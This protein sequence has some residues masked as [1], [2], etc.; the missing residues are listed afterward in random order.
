MNKGF[1][2]IYDNVSGMAE[3]FAS[4]WRSV[5][6]A[7]ASTDGVFGYELINEP[8]GGNAVGHL[9]YMLPG[10]AG[11]RNLEPLYERVRNWLKGH[12]LNRNHRKLHENC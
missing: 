6:S 8:W 5:A 10:V 9:S 2:D 4:F 3:R 12:W 11:R 7:F 1:Q